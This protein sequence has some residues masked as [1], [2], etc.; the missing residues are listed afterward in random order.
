[1]GV[2]WSSGSNI[3][4]FFFN[5]FIS[6]GFGIDVDLEMMEN[7][8]VCICKFLWLD[9]FEWLFCVDNG[10]DEDLIVVVLVVEKMYLEGDVSDRVLWLECW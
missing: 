6:F 8:R 5:I 2:I 10:L 4:W 1:M 9:G 3:G 7:L